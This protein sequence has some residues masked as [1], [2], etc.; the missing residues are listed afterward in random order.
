M[1]VGLTGSLD[2][3][4]E[5]GRKYEGDQCQGLHLRGFSH[6]KRSKSG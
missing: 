2:L 6:K 3:Q 5:I 1:K 4:E